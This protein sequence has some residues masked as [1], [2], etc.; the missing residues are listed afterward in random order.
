MSSMINADNGTLD[1][2]PGLRVN[3]VKVATKPHYDVL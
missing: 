2:L 1:G 3:N